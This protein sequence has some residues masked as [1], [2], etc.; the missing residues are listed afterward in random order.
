MAN[1]SKNI[2]HDKHLKYY[3]FYEESKLN[4]SE[5]WGIGIENESYLMFETL[6]SEKRQ[7]FINNRKK[8]RYSVDYWTNFKIKK[9]ENTLKKLPDQV[10]IPIY[11]NGYLFQNTDLFGEPRRRYTKLAEPNP[12]FNGQSID[13]YLK[14]NSNI[15]NKLFDK[16]MIFDGDTF[17]FTT[18]DFYKTNVKNVINELITT[19]KTFIDEIN[20]K[21]VKP[22]KYMNDKKYIFKDKII[23]PKYNYGFA[24]FQTNLNN[25][26]VC[27]NGT[28]HINI[29]LPTQLNPDKTIKNP[30]KFKNIHSNAIRAIQW[31]EPFLIAL[32]GSPD[33]LHILNEKYAG[34]SLRLM[35]SRYIGLGTY[36]SNEMSKGKMLND[37]NYKNKNHYFEKLHEKSPYN[38]PETIG[39]DFNYNKFVKH[40][41]ELRI[42]DY[43]PE[44]YLEDIMNFLILLCDFSIHADFPDPV[45][46]EDWNK[47]VINIL[48]EGSKAKLPIVLKNKINQLFITCNLCCYSFFKTEDSPTIFQFMN[49]FSKK[50]YKNQRKS[51]LCKKMSPNMKQIKFVDYNKIMKKEFRKVIAY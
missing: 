49:S 37:F 17:E 28:Y 1:D 8:E 16:S 15:Y 6:I 50:L 51:P 18:F 19:K 4:D 38:P 2:L 23:Y 40:G 13:E 5:Y 44:E 31:F 35:L 27:N 22:K 11:L 43:F 36:N 25:I 32:Y 29:T 20:T 42:F 9:L 45:L 48:K 12:N 14:K 33:I 3:K 7:F 24:K 46:D 30:E 34:G 39:Y 26:A 10:K 47:F 21:L 41:I